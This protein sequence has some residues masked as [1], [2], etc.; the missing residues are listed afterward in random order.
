MKR[1]IWALI[2]AFAMLSLLPAQAQEEKPQPIAIIIFEPELYEAYQ[3]WAKKKVGELEELA[4]QARTISPQVEDVEFRGWCI[5]AGD[6]QELRE[7]ALSMLT[8]EP[9]IGDDGRRRI[10]VLPHPLPEEW[11]ADAGPDLVYPII[12]EFRKHFS[13]EAFRVAREKQGRKV[14][15][16]LRRD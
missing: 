15:S 9:E 12:R 8:A 4:A 7:F 2:P 6:P 5:R 3:E 13:E 10:T 11:P 1:W 16:L 14:R